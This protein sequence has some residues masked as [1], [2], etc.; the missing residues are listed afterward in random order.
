MHGRT[1]NPRDGKENQSGTARATFHEAS[2]FALA[3]SHN[4]AY[5]ASRAIIGKPER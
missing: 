5:V 4:G 1:L 3:A 2:A